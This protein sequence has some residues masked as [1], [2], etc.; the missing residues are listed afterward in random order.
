MPAKFDN[1]VAKIRSSRLLHI[2]RAFERGQELAS[3]GLRTDPDAVQIRT[4]TGAGIYEES[5]T[6]EVYINKMRHLPSHIFI[7]KVPT[8]KNFKRGNR[9][10][11]LRRF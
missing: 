2:S 4:E 1:V 8:R 7:A 10:K 3:F 6:I 9:V 5:Y 11:T